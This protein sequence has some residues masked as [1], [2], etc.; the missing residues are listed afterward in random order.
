[1]QGAGRSA[2]AL[3]GQRRGARA[4]G[5]AMLARTGRGKAC[6][7][8]APGVVPRMRTA[9]STEMNRMARSTQASAASVASRGEGCFMKARAI[10]SSARI[11]SVK[12]D[13]GDPRD[14]VSGAH[15]PAVRTGDRQ[16]H[17][18]TRPRRIPSRPGRW[19]GAKSDRFERGK[20]W[21]GQPG[22]NAWERPAKGPCVHASR[23]CRE[24][25]EK[26]AIAPSIARGEPR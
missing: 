10:V 22:I 18:R 2:I 12:G 21:T 5:T 4:R 14:C 9:R 17:Q 8:E 3:V 24:G 16:G 19:P 26:S 7:Y 25:D 23:S 13:G 15:A 1:M 11:S 6:P 20:R